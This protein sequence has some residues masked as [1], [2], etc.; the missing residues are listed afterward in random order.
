MFLFT[1]FTLSYGIIYHQEQKLE[2][3]LK[4][5]NLKSI[6]GAFPRPKLNV[7]FLPDIHWSY[8]NHSQALRLPELRCKYPWTWPCTRKH[9]L[10]FLHPF[11]KKLAYSWSLH[12][13][14]AICNIEFCF[15]SLQVKLGQTISI[16]VIRRH[17]RSQPWA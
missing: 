1:I 7:V 13:F 6:L 3:S 17:R 15:C 8:C 9:N 14:Q 4:S 11:D 16:D 10:S 12:N 5:G 2:K